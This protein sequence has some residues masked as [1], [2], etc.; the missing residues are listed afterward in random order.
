MAAA[1]GRYI[2]FH[3]SKEVLKGDSRWTKYNCRDSFHSSKEVLKGRQWRRR[4]AATLVSIP[5]RKF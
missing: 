2:S 4:V 1:G 3:S 5:L